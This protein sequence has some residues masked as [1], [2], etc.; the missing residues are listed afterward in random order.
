M[1]ARITPALPSG[2]HAGMGSEAEGV[3]TAGCCTSKSLCESP[4]SGLGPL[5][6]RGGKQAGQLRFLCT[7]LSTDRGTLFCG[8]TS[9][10]ILVT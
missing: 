7:S 5:V 3:R 4:C 2:A 1:D 6:G 9:L 10:W 8:E